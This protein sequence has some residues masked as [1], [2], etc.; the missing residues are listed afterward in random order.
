[1]WHN[2][3]ILHRR[4]VG[5]CCQ[6]GSGS[7]RTCGQVWCL[8]SYEFCLFGPRDSTV[9]AFKQES[10][11]GIRPGVILL[12]HIRHRMPCNGTHFE[13]EIHLIGGQAIVAWVHWPL[14]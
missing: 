4:H 13:A 5:I 11:Y 6:L 3:R 9:V 1:V 8:T 14:V 2:L 10:T 12:R 7:Y